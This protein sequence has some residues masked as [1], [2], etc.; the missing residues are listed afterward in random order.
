MDLCVGL[1]PEGW[2][3]GGGGRCFGLLL[4]DVDTGNE[5]ALETGC[6]EL[7]LPLLAGEVGLGVVDP[8]LASLVPPN[9]GSSSPRMPPRSG[10]LVN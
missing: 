7:L 10:M 6:A 3:L 1:R 9:G 5:A 8:L 2:K 4:F